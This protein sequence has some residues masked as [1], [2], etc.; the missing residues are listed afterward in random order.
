M[1]QLKEHVSQSVCTRWFDLG[2][3]LLDAKDE[4]KIGIIEASHKME[5]VQT[6]CGKMF[7][8]WLLYDN[9]NW[10][11]LVKAMRKIGLNHA[12]SEIEKLFKCEAI[13]MYD[14]CLCYSSS[15]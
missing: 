1:K 2:L 4:Q 6:C 8:T 9:A 3:E 5:G 12:A 15:S 10:D 7:E 14:H 13:L 11:Q